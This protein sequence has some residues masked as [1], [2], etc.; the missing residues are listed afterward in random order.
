[1]IGAN[2]GSIMAMTPAIGKHLGL[3]IFSFII[4]DEAQPIEEAKFI[5]RNRDRYFDPKF[6][7]AAGLTPNDWSDVG[8]HQANDQVGNASAV[9]V[10]EDSLLTH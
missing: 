5:S 2:N 1:L 10:I 4:W 6:Y 9:R 8:L 7:I 3:Q